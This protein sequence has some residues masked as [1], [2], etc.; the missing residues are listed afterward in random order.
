MQGLEEQLEKAISNLTERVK[1]HQGEVAFCLRE[2]TIP[3]EVTG[4]FLPPIPHDYYHYN[5]GIITGEVQRNEE[6]KF[7]IIK[8][9]HMT[10]RPMGAH[11]PDDFIWGNYSIPVDRNLKG[12]ANA[13][14]NLHFNISTE[15]LE[16]ISSGQILLDIRDFEDQT[17]IAL[18]DRDRTSHLT[19]TDILIGNEEVEKFLKEKQFKDYQEFFDILR[20]PV[21]VEGKISE[22][23]SQKA[24][25]LGEEIVI[26]GNFVSN[27]FRKVKE[28]E[29]G[30]MHAHY[31]SG[32][33][34]DEKS[35]DKEEEVDAYHGL[36]RV[37]S[38]NLETLK[39]QLLKMEDPRLKSK[40]F[41]FFDGEAIGFRA[42]VLVSDQIGY[43]RGT[44]IPEIEGTLEKI[45]SYLKGQMVK[46]YSG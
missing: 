38:R 36:K 18:L 34:S 4:D 3:G 24:R 45:D 1:Q 44:M 8:L 32:A 40:N 2:F 14:G 46:A 30:V 35:W 23:Y 16:G 15:A 26:T 10:L 7:D 42:R 19:R 41:Q 37:I 17:L 25:R 39:K 9:P 6:P 20:N 33:S 27:T 21:F 12:F 31:I 13:F 29:E 22:Y 11:E 28:L 5:A 43:L